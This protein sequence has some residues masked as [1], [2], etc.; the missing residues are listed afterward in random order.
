MYPGGPSPAHFP[1]PSAVTGRTRPAARVAAGLLWAFAAVL[2]LGAQ[3]GAIHTRH[4]ASSDGDDR[5]ITGFWQVRTTFNGSETSTL[6]LGGVTVLIATVVLVVASLLVF[7]TRQRWGAAVV[8]A[9]GAGMVLNQAVSNV[10][11]VLAVPGLESVGSGWWLIIGAA[12]VALA[13]LT[14]ALT[15]RP[16]RPAG[17]YPVGAPFPPPDHGAPARPGVP[18]AHPGL[19]PYPGG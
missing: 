5:M 1:P 11:F 9:L 17:P 10:V 19:P 6:A 18:P 8:G 2:A 15:E 13:A 7:V 3:F 14:V 4:L 12:T 16:D